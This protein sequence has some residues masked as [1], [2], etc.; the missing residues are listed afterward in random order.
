MIG[1]LN[2]AA[3]CLVSRFKPRARLEA[4]NIALRHQLNVL[5]RTVR[6]RARVGTFD[7]LIL[8]WLYRLP[9]LFTSLDVAKSDR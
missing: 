3:H 1:Y 9:P 5:R 7:R 4:E 2:L 8:V 6:S